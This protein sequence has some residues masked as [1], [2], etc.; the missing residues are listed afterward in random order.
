MQP[1]LD[2]TDT[3][4]AFWQPWSRQLVDAI[5][6]VRSVVLSELSDDAKR[7]QLD[8]LGAEVHKLLCQLD[9]RP[10]PCG[11][12]GTVIDALRLPLDA[13]PIRLAD[14]I[15]RLRTPAALSLNCPPSTAASR[16]GRTVG[17]TRTVGDQQELPGLEPINEGAT[18]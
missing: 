8:Q 16:G 5:D 14:A 12:L 15:D 1:P 9:E 4:L 3:E 13:E 6:H 18:T 11:D 10:S 17:R 7:S 2:L